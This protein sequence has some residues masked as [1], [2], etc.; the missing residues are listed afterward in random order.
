MLNLLKGVG[1]YIA[2]AVFIL[3][4]FILY[5]VSIEI[6]QIILAL[7]MPIIIVTWICIG[8]NRIYQYFKG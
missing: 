3:I 5:V 6:L 8:I 4:V 2:S 7:M 1:L